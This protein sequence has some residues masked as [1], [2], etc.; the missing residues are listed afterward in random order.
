MKTYS[1]IEDVMR[2]SP[3]PLA[4]HEFVFVVMP[5]PDG[6]GHVVDGREYIGVTE[7]TLGR[8]LREMRGFGRVTAHRREGKAFVEYALPVKPQ[9]PELIFTDNGHTGGY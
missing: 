4:A 1:L 3:K 9:Q 7:S 5:G 8:R 6:P 2:R